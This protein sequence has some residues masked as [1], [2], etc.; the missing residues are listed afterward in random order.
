MRNRTTGTQTGEAKR[1]NEEAQRQ[2]GEA[3]RQNGENK[4]QN[5]EDKKA[6][7]RGQKGE[8]VKGDIP[9]RSSVR[10]Q[11]LVWQKQRLL[12]GLLLHLG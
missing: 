7:W 8:P 10:W 9:V 5:G 12:P 4:R 2:N 1:Q 11:K 3:Q 6:D